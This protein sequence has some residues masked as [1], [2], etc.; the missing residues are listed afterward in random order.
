MD[1]YKLPTRL[2]MFVISVFSH[3]KPV[4]VVDIER[5]ILLR[6]SIHFDCDAY[7]TNLMVLNDQFITISQLNVS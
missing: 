7:S 1:I 5:A 2:L 6:N 3:R 4:V